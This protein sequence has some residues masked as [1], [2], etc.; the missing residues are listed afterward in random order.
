M[1][2]GSGNIGFE[3]DDAEYGEKIIYEGRKMKVPDFVK[4]LLSSRKFWIAVL[5]VVVAGVM[6]VR[7]EITAEQFANA[8]VVLCV[9]VIGGITLEDSA[10]KAG[11][12]YG[13]IMSQREKSD[14]SEQSS[15][16][17]V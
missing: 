6:F 10:S 5:G 11:M 2:T 3:W 1:F 7:G 12:A 9:V 13:E 17:I 4:A 8:L 16:R 14:K 15:P